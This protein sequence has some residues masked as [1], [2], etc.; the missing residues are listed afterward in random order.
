[1]TLDSAEEVIN[2]GSRRARRLR[3]VKR[4]HEQREQ[5]WSRDIC[6]ADA[7]R[8]SRRATAEIEADPKEAA[9][10][11]RARQQAREGELVS[12]EEL[13]REFESDE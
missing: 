5:A 3:E 7:H 2:Q 6:L 13:D 4:K 10:L 8:A 9:G 12:Q 1:M 11:D